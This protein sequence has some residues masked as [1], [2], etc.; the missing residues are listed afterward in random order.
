MLEKV[1]RI[2]AEIGE[3]YQWRPVTGSATFGPLPGI[4]WLIPA[5]VAR[6][7]LVLFS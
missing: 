7:A 5:L 1:Y 6:T 4:R 2:I 3:S